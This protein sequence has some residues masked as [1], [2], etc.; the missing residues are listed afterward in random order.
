MEQLGLL[1]K[2][3]AR[4]PKPLAVLCMNIDNF[5]RVNESLG[6]SAGDLLLQEAGNRMVGCLRASDMLAVSKSTGQGLNVSRLG[7][8]EFAV[9]LNALD[10]A[11]SAELVA[12][13]IIDSMA[14]PMTIADHEIVVAPRIGIA[15]APRDGN[16]PEDLLCNATTALHHARSDSKDNVRFFKR[17]M[18]PS[19]QEDLRLEADLRRAIEGRQLHLHYQPQVDTTDGSIT[20]AEALLRWNHAELGEISPFRFVPIAEKAGLIV[21]LGEWVIGEACRQMKA[22]LDQGIELPRMAINI[23]PRQLQ[24]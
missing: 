21:S 2:L 20:C 13:R 22:C 8:D 12:R 3:S 1:L 7:G 14:Q 16:E 11:E 15:V 24:S 6:R 5:N 9:V 4:D 18:E 10:K 17:D 23:S 19:G